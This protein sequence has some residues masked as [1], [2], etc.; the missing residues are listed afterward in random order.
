MKNFLSREG[1]EPVGS[2]PAE[3]AAFLNREIDKF[4][5]IVK[6]AGVKPEP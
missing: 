3:A 2:T 6:A 5:K 1:V 4:A